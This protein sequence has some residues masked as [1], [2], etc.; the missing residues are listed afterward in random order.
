MRPRI[1][2]CYN[3]IEVKKMEEKISSQLIYDGKIIKLY[4]DKVLCSNGNKA[5]REV[6]RHNGGVGILAIVDN[7]ILLVEQYRYPNAINT[8]EIPAGK[9]EINENPESCAFRELEEETGYSAKKMTK[10]SKFLPTPGYSDE[11][12]YIYQAQDVYKVENPRPC[13]DDEMIEVIALDI[14]EAYHQV[15]NGKIIDSKTIIAIMHAYINN[16]NK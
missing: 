16:Q 2:F 10:I 1:L 4:K 3:L 14:N 9:L 6:V 13:D 11:W 15:I 8:L 12:L 5:T 7:K